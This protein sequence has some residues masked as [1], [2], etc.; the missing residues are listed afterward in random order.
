METREGLAPKE[1][2]FKKGVNITL[3]KRQLLTGETSGVTVGSAFNGRLNDNIEIGKPIAMETINTTTVKGITI[4]E[5]TGRILVDTE[6]SRY[7]LVEK[8]VR[9]LEMDSELGSVHLPIDSQLAKLDN[10][11]VDFSFF[12]EEK[13][14]KIHINKPALKGVLMESGGAQIFKAMKGRFFV[15]AKVRN[16]H[17]PFY[18]SSEGTSGKNAGEWY[19]FFGETSSW[20]VKGG[21]GPKG[22]MPY[23]SEVDKVTE[24]LNQ[25]LILPDRFFSLKGG[26]IGNQVRENEPSFVV[27]D[28]NNHLLYRPLLS[29]FKR[30]YQEFTRDVTGY[31]PRKVDMEN[32]SQWIS[33]II[34]KIK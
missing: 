14:H 2:P 21:L 34:S 18:I 4:N 22:K 3:A 25:N 31:D 26:K 28:L 7:E 6:N 19:P 30:P 32:S 15:L 29:S 9:G 24:L 5:A 16:I 11:V 20:V 27:F 10:Q 23:H 13:E 12:A 8:D 1:S 17:L 33:S